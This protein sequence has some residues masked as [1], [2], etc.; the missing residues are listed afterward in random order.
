[1]AEYAMEQIV[2]E[3]NQLRKDYSLIKERS[4]SDFLLKLAESL[5]RT[6]YLSQQKCTQAFLKDIKANSDNQKSITLHNT[7]QH[8]NSTHDNIIFSVFDSP[9]FPDLNIEICIYE[10]III[11]MDFLNQY[12]SNVMPVNI[13]Q[14]SE[15]FYSNVVVAL[16]PENHIDKTQV[17][18]DVIFYF[19]DKFVKR[20]FKITHKMILNTIADNFFSELIN[21]DPMKI[22]EWSVCWVHL[23]EH[24]HHR[25]FLPLPEFIGLKS[26]KPLAGLEELR[27][28]V[29]SI[30]A[31]LEDGNNAAFATS[32]ARFILAERLLR[33]AVEGIPKPNY[34][35]I[36]SQLLFN[37]LKQEG[38]IYIENLK[39]YLS[40]TIWTG[41]KAFL[42]IIN[43]IESEIQTQNPKVVQKKLL[44]FTKQ[45]TNF[46]EATQEFHHINYFKQI[47]ECLCV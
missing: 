20:F 11:N 30:I 45:Y 7:K 29:C 40:N 44:D 43:D 21:A 39:I 38:Y 33:Y 12:P 24:Y 9:Y 46:N 2:N 25:G 14:A 35:A 17:K 34:D 3:V 6:T 41:L 28:D 42:N 47:K 18:E 1:M 4:S 5:K 10:P 26:L 32:A 13:K 37:Y 23:H 27:V 31:L 36:A 22:Q 8:I 19:I 16:F 15:G